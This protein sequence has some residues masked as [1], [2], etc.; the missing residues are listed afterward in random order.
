[1][2]SA[3]YESTVSVQFIHSRK[4]GQFSRNKIENNIPAHFFGSIKHNHWKFYQYKKR[5]TRKDKV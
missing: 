5:V 3:D 4:S 2:F 1:M